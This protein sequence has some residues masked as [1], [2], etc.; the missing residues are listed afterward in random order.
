MERRGGRGAVVAHAVNDPRVEVQ[1]LPARVDVAHEV[2]QGARAA[3]PGSLPETTV[4]AP[5]EPA[6]S[7]SS[8]S[9]P[10]IQQISQALTCS[11]RKISS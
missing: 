8:V 5:A 9:W 2:A 10:G 6:W 4:T 11:S 3:V 7:W 1:D